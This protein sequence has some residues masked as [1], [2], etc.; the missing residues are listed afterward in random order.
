MS[1]LYTIAFTVV[2]PLA[3]IGT[4]LFAK[5]KTKLEWLLDGLMTFF[6]VTWLFQSGPWSWFGYALRYLLLVFL[7][8]AI[9]L[10]WR[11]IRNLPFKNTYSNYQKFSMGVAAVMTLIFALFN[12]IILTGYSTNDPGLDLEFPLKEGTYYIGQ[13]GNQVQMNYHQEYEPQKYAL[14]ILAVNSYG[15]RARGLYPTDL[16]KYEIYGHPITSPCNGIVVEAKDGLTD[17]QPPE[18]DPE[19]ATGN[20]V[21]LTCEAA[22]DTIVYLAHMQKDS[23]AVAEGMDVEV[24]QLLG[25]VG[26]TGNTS[27]PHLHI[28]AEKDGVGIPLF[29]DERF[30]VRNHVVR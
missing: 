20:Y 7:F 8:V 27:E 5:H 4:L 6:F 10:A 18:A 1:T 11:K 9:G 3:F 14:D 2:L 29:F 12:G 24:G 22:E 28:H 16:E 15:I 23:L 25:K 13:G 17:L 21:A 26:N 19:N 30:L